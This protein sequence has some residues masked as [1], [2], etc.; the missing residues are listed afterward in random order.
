MVLRKMINH[1]WTRALLH[2][3]SI[4]QLG[5]LFVT[6]AADRIPAILGVGWDSTGP[7]LEATMYGFAIFLRYTAMAVEGPEDVIVTGMDSFF[8]LFSAYHQLWQEYQTLVPWLAT[9]LR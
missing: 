1:C 9:L 4:F 2:N 8:G 6:I 3:N 5:D 7:I